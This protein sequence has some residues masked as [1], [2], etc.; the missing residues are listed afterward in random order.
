[1]T[2]TEIDLAYLETIHA[3]AKMMGMSNEDII[4]LA[5]TQG[6]IDPEAFR[7]YEEKYKEKS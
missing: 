5:K 4:K 6:G 2:D 7:L 1:M 3:S